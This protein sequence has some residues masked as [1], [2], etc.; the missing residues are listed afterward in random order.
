MHIRCV[1]VIDVFD[2]NQKIENRNFVAGPARSW[3][4]RQPCASPITSL[5]LLV[6]IR[7]P[8]QKI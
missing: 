7:L 1:M 2:E 4:L 6:V 3:V 5:L 8:K